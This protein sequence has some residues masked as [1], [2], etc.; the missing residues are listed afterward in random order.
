MSRLRNSDRLPKTGAAVAYAER[1]HNGQRRGVDGAPFI[2]HPL[3]VAAL[4]YYAGAPDHLIAAGA[5]H[6]AIEKTDVDSAELRDRFGERI[7]SLVEAVSENP[8]IP[9]Y[10][11]RKAALR[12]QVAGAG[13]EALILFAAD[14]LAKVRE[15]RAEIAGQGDGAPPDSRGHQ[16]AHLRGGLNLLEDALPDSPLVR[17]LRQELET[18]RD[19]SS[20]R[21]MLVAQAPT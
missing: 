11:E 5:L 12:Q 4:L 13:E 8:R 21:R 6:D 17:E 9:G 16:L 7:T 20:D 10:I 18:I 19:A 1:V 2:T 3:E 14:K 15:L